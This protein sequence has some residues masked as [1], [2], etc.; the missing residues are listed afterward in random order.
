M[1]QREWF[2]IVF[3]RV[4]TGVVETPVSPQ[5]SNPLPEELDKSRVY[6]KIV[7]KFIFIAPMNKK[8]L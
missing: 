3:K 8:S 6:Y 4:L 1:P 7:F 2:E 5:I